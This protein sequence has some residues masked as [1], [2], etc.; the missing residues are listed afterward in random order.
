MC[1][2]SD[3]AIHNKQRIVIGKAA[4]PADPDNGL[5]ARQAAGSN[6]YSRR[7][8]LQCSNNILGV[9][10]P[11]SI[12]IDHRYR[13]GQVFFL[14]RSV[15]YHHQLFQRLAVLSKGNSKFGTVLHRHRLRYVAH[16]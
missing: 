2:A 16:K 14:H 10:V 12:R 15:A 5:L 9:P 4:Q 13:T 3:H 11:Q 6:A 8:P 1:L 7:Q